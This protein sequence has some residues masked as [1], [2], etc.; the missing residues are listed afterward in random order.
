MSI[1]MAA[2][3]RMA[4]KSGGTVPDPTN[5]IGQCIQYRI[6]MGQAVVGN[7]PLAPIT[8]QTSAANVWIGNDPR[9][10]AFG[11]TPWNF[12]FL[13][14]N[15]GEVT[16]C[17]TN[18]NVMTGPFTGCYAFVYM[19]AGQ[20]KLAHV[21]TNLTPDNPG[22]IRAKQIWQNIVAGGAMN[23]KGESPAKHF[24]FGELD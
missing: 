1:K 21:G 8:N 9:N 22:S 14:F 13:K 12:T 19:D 2:I 7:G 16:T 3:W 6:D 23:I 10:P 11:G 18:G 4:D 15:A 17:P 20:Q 24:T 5:H